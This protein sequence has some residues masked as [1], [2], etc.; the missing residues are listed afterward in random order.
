M[1]P[2]EHYTGT[3]RHPIGLARGFALA[4][5]SFIDFYTAKSLSLVAYVHPHQVDVVQ[6]L[7]ASMSVVCAIGV[8]GV[9]ISW[10]FL[11]RETH[12]RFTLGVLVI[13][14]VGLTLDVFALLLSALV[15]QRANPLYLL[16]EAALVHIATVALFSVWYSSIDHPRQVARSQGLPA[17]QGI[18]FPQHAARYEGYADWVP[19]YFDYLSFAFTTSST[20]GPTEAIPLAVPIKLLIMLQVSFSLNI[21]LVLAARAIGLIQ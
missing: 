17:R 12:R 11:L 18:S 2:R 5:V 3:D 14:T 19:G 7:E 1:I 6:A 15:G 10:P 8:L 4:V 16:L 21:L 9:L 13:Q 20:L